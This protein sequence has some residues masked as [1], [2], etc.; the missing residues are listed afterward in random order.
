M[1]L[2]CALCERDILSN[3]CSVFQISPNDCEQ[4][5][6]KASEV[7]AEVGRGKTVAKQ[8]V[9]LA[10]LYEEQGNLEKAVEQYQIA[11]DMFSGE[12]RWNILCF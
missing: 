11:A 5:L 9:T 1:C 4:C 8:H 12:V 6:I 7:Y 10:E 3:Y 2:I